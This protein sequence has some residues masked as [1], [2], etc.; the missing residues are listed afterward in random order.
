MGLTLSLAQ[1]R[2]VPKTGGFIF[3][4]PAILAALGALGSLAGGSAA[5]AKTVIDAKKNKAQLEEQKSHNE[6][7]QASILAKGKVLKKKKKKT[8]LKKVRLPI[9]TLSV[10]LDS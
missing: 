6:K 10:Q 4:I 7:I 1:L 8:I 5:I 2:K 9:M 3:T